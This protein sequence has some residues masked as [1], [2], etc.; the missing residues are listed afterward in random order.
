MA[1][2]ATVGD[3]IAQLGRDLKELAQKSK[4]LSKGDT[5]RRTKHLLKT[6]LANSQ[7]ETV[8]QPYAPFGDNALA[9]KEWHV[10]ADKLAPADRVNQRSQAQTFATTAETGLP[11]DVAEQ[12]AN[13]AERLHGLLEALGTQLQTSQA[14]GVGWSTNK[15]RVRVFAAVAEQRRNTTT[16]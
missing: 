16:H 12:V 1:R 3:A 9:V 14:S 4:S 13:N 6:T 15:T 10:I 7:L 8:T 2:A 11:P 5:H